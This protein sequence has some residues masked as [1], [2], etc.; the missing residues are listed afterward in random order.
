MSSF[1]SGP[2]L[3]HMQSR[4]RRDDPIED[5]SWPPA[6]AV[7]NQAVGVMAEEFNCTVQEAFAAMT[8]RA[9]AVGPPLEQIATRVIDHQN[10]CGVRP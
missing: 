4:R 5:E 10:R 1:S 2:R 7:V 9:A 3:A 6:S 8:A